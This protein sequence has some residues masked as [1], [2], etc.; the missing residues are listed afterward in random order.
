MP[1]RKAAAE[2]ADGGATAFTDGEIKL[3]KAVFDSM[4]TRPD[5]DFENV[6]NIMGL[7]NAKSARDRFRVVSKKHGWT[8]TDG[9]GGAAGG[10]GD[11]SSKA[12]GP[13][14]PKNTTKV[15]KKPAPKKKGTARKKHHFQTKKEVES[16][17]DEDITGKLESDSDGKTIP[18]DEPMESSSEDDD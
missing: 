6:A 18:K 17:D 12:K 5:I 2:N 8:S 7:A 14:A 16:D 13:L 11:G 4:N 3:V 15:T 1:P 10:G 9:S